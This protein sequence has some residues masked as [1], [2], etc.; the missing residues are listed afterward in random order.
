[1]RALLPGRSKWSDVYVLTKMF[2]RFMSEVND[3]RCLKAAKAAAEQ[4]SRSR[5][6]LAQKR[7]IV[8]GYAQAA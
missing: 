2:F 3:F 6:E 5:V 7:E 8:D 4:D 1:M